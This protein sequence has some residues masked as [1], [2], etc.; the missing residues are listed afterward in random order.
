MLNAYHEAAGALAPLPQGASLT[1][2]VWIDLLDPT[3]AEAQSVAALGIDVPTLA[4]MEEIEISNRLYREGP[5]DYMTV[6]LPGH[7]S[8]NDPISGPVSFILSPDRLVTVRH[9][10]SRPF[11]T[12]PTRAGKTGPGCGSA[13]AVFLSLIEEITGRIADLLESVGRSLDQLG[14]TIHDRTHR[15][16][17][18]DRL[19]VALRSL[20]REGHLIGILRL[21]LLT[22]DRAVGFY[23][24]PDR[25]ADKRLDPALKALR[26]DINAL[27]V[28][29]DFL[30]SRVAQATDLT[31]G[32]INLAQNATFRI[33]SVVTV[34]FSPPLLIAA[35]YGMNFQ[36][37][38][39]LA[40][41]YG[42][43]AA[44]VAMV[45]SSLAAFLYFRWKNWL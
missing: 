14:T 5:L 27:E 20:G 37:M 26:R 35:I 21:S 1:D 36:A 31:L 44:L 29:T 23:D 43:P 18:Q 34:L 9:H 42:Y 28:H 13:H 15:R 32:M 11:E 39:E 10:R 25:K 12:Y 8:G 2:A 22:I 45:C 40:T 24:Q 41:R 38:P 19:E 3:E 33:L 4:D 30:S 17:G 16:K 6:V 7:T